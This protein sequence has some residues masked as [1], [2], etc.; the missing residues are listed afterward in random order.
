MMNQF[1]FDL[2]NCDMPYSLEVT[3]CIKAQNVYPISSRD[4]SIHVTFENLNVSCS[5]QLDVTD[6]PAGWDVSGEVP[7]SLMLLP[8]QYGEGYIG[9]NVKVLNRYN[10]FEHLPFKYIPV[11]ETLTSTQQWIDSCPYDSLKA[12]MYR[13]L[14]S[15][16][17]GGLFF[18]IPAST[19]KY[20]REPGGLA[21]HSLE[22]AQMV[23]SSTACF[24]ECERWLAAV[25]GLFHEV[26]RVRISS[27]DSRLKATAGLVSCEV[28]NFE[29]LGPALQLLEKEWTDGAEA[30]RYMLDSL[31]RVRKSC[32]HL[33]IALSVRSA[34][35]MSMTNN[36][37]YQ[38]F[39]EN[40]QSKK[41]ARVGSS[42]AEMFWQPSAP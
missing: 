13:V 42:S 35:L 33:P 10:S 17:I 2:E 14:G 8:D 28:L 1:P 12:F 31:C 40:S 3:G 9:Q 5:V 24:D 39:Q 36:H 29:V 22:V 18:S 19:H 41:F 16:S 11:R 6:H 4:S 34:D 37:R 21:K 26:G 32:P 15:P 25:A 23:Y 20:F 30:I 27:G 7:V 38:A